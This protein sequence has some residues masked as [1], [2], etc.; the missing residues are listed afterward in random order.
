MK[1]V[2]ALTLVAALGL[3]LAQSAGT[4][5]PDFR[6]YNTAGKL[7]KLSGFKGKPVVLN[8][9]ATWCVVCNAE[10]PEMMRVAAKLRG[11]FVFLG[12]HRDESVPNAQVAEHA[13]SHHHAFTALMVNPPNGKTDSD[14]IP[15]VVKRYGIS[16]RRGPSSSTRTAWC[17]LFR[18]EG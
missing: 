9:W 18:P 13:K 8:F 4:P 17:A 1:H 2:L 6:L 15:D 14:S 3:A 10:L 5:A 11:E 16:A 7:V 12:V